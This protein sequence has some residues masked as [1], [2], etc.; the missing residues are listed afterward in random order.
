MPEDQVPPDQL[1]TTLLTIFS[2]GDRSSGS[3]RT[4]L[5]WPEVPFDTFVNDTVPIEVP[6]LFRSFQVRLDLQS[7]PVKI[8][9]KGYGMFL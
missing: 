3:I 1:T 6:L 4:Q 8:V 9:A 7:H 2:C 5:G